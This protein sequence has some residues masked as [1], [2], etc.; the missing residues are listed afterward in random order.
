MVRH[1]QLRAGPGESLP[2]GTSGPRLAVVTA[3]G[4]GTARLLDRGAQEGLR[5]VLR[6]SGASTVWVAVHGGRG[7]VMLEVSDDGQGLPPDLAERRL[8]GHVGL[9]ALNGLA[10]DAGG[11]LTV[12]PRHPSGTTLRLTVP[13]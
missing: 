9:T 4:D 13:L 1:R 11:T 2:P 10:Q 8:A 12:L 7:T 6:H 3:T 5:N